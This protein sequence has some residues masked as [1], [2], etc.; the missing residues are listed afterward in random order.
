MLRLPAMAVVFDNDGVLVDSTASVERSW[1]AWA[2]SRALDPAEIVAVAHGRPSRD[3]VA[4][5]VSEADRLAALAEV[6]ELELRDTGG[7]TAVPGAVELVRQMPA[8]RWA[9]VTSGNRALAGARIAAAGLPV[10]RILITSDDVRRGKPDPEG[11]ALALRRLG[12][13]PR[14]AV[15]LEDAPTGIAAA[16][17]AGVETIVGLGAATLEAGVT[18]AVADL[19][20]VRW[21]DGLLVDPYT[22]S[23]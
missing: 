21:D 13:S 12:V 23:L 7:V 14:H 15:V 18:I 17:A 8:D 4:M 5:F 2:A 10:P 3:T 9:V 16:R 22:G 20:S 11:Y 19:R 1:T 6:D